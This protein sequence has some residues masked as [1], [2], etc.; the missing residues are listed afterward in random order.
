MFFRLI[1]CDCENILNS[2]GGLAVNN[3]A[4]QLGSS[5]ART[6]PCRYENRGLSVGYLWSHSICTLSDE[7]AASKQEPACVCYL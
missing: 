1:E 5:T 2:L 4:Y 3:E 6:A 7:A